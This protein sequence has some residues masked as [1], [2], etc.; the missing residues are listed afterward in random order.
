MK[1]TFL[2][3]SHGDPTVD[4]FNSSLLLETAGA[5]YLIDCGSPALASLVRRG[6]N[7]KK[8]RGIF[9]S[10]MHLDHSGDLLNVLKHLVK[11]KL[12]AHAYL[13][14]PAAVSPVD[15]FLRLAYPVPPGA[16]VKYHLIQPGRFYS[17]EN[18]SMEAVPNNHG[19]GI[20]PSYSFLIEASGR[21]ILYTGDLAADLKDFPV[22]AAESADLCICELTHAPPEIM[23]K[24]M[25]SLALKK[26][27]FTHIGPRY[28]KNGKVVLPQHLSFPVVPARD[29]DVFCLE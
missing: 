27:I 26:V 28:E 19:H 16:E 3:T 12:D 24:K 11:H 15:S 6:I 25:R 2:G 10:H 1:I 23:E 20:F 5:G 9:I 8:L 21:K 29:G 4:R 14:D 17:D 22:K 13:P 7:F 18:L